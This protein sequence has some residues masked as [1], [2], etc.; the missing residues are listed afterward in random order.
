MSVT[1]ELGK[2]EAKNLELPPGFSVGG[3]T[4]ALE[5]SPTSSQGVP[6]QDTESDSEAGLNPRHRCGNTTTCPIHLHSTY[7]FSFFL[8]WAI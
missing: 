4:Q 1:A 8:L 6:Q 3:R 7:F 2:A 5:L